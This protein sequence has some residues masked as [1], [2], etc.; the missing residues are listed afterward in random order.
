M[1]FQQN[2]EQNIQLCDFNFGGSNLDT[3]VYIF[4]LFS[5]IKKFDIAFNAC[6]SLV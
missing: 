4:L 3:L 5:F 1:F 2:Y 6:M